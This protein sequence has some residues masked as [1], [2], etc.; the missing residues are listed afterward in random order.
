MLIT[1]LGNV[2]VSM[3]SVNVSF[4]S[5][6]SSLVIEILNK[7]LVSPAGIVTLYGPG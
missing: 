1:P 6:A 3:D 4:P 5:T 2:L 7:S